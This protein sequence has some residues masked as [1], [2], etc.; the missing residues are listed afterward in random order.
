MMDL[1]TAI[2]I[3]RRYLHLPVQNGA[4]MR[5]VRVTVE[6]EV[7]RSFEIEL[8]Q[9]GPDF[10]V[11]CDLS[12]FQGKPARIEVQAEDCD[13][14]LL[15]PIAQSDQFPGAAEM[16]REALRPQFH[17]SSQ[18]GWHNDPNGLV[19]YGGQY[20]LFYQHNPYGIQWGNMHWGHAVSGD[21]VHWRELGDALYPDELGMAFSGCG[22]VDWENSSG[23][24]EGEHPPL[25]CVY[26][27]AGDKTP[28][29]SGQPFTQSLLY[30]TDGGETWRTYEANP[31]LGH[32][33]GENRDPKV[34][35]HAP[36]GQWVMALYL[37][38]NDYALY[39]SPDLKAWTKLCDVVLPDCTE[40]PD[41]FPLA[42]DG[43][44]ED[45]R[46]VFWGANGTYLLGSFDGQT[47]VP[48]G[49]AQRYDWG[50]NAYAAQTW[51]D[52]PDR[53][54]QI[55]WLRVD[56]PGM[57][58]SQQMTFPCELTLCRTPDGVRLCS[59]PVR[60]IE[61]LYRGSFRWQDL[62][63]REGENPLAGVRGDLLD[64]WVE[65]EAGGPGTALC[66][67]LRGIEMRYDVAAGQ[68]TCQGRT[69]P[70][71][72]VDGRVRLRALLDRCSLEIWGNDGIV[73]LALGV[74][75]EADNH[76]L[77]SLGGTTRV[78]DLRV[79]ELCSI[80]G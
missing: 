49:P 78:I 33:A 23:L 50:G 65:F 30:S 51:S 29:S 9:G 40:C 47:F 34:I 18:R 12:P 44:A 21:L 67:A 19:Y 75:P 20:H 10:W 59:W 6:G 39:G 14:A 28:E 31:V 60:E 3:E 66:L 72:P 57:P 7:V 15:E 13:P 17:F 70:L 27:S 4:P 42:V 76:A 71:Q 37:D 45:V 80:W 2:L 35:W 56:P 58:F 64:V 73:T 38:G 36:S 32:V 41:F 61:A 16:H 62:D 52:V 48:D 68:L 5:R 46:W 55:V 24:R 1:S 22:V 74:V 8:A 54:I 69:L 25:V 11:A 63:L 26:T 53:R 77:A 43:D 79:H